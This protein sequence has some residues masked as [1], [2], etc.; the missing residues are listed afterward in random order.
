M[1]EPLKNRYN[2]AF[3]GRLVGELSAH[4]APFDGDAFARQLFDSSWPE[5]ELKQRMRHITGTLH[6]YLPA[7]YRQTLEILKPVSR[8]FSGFEPMFFPDYVECYG[9]DDYQAS[10]PALAHFTQYS[11]SEFAVR[12]FIERYGDEMMLQMQRW[13]ESDNHH[14]RR[15]ASEGCRPRL[16]WAMAL[17]A[18]KKNPEAV[19]EVISKMRCDESE[20]VR[21]SVANNLND[22]SKDHPERLLQLAQAWL[23]EDEK[24]DWIVKHACRSE[25]K[26]GV[27]EVLK[28]FG[29]DDPKHIEISAF[30]LQPEVKMGDGVGF[31]FQLTT[32]KKSLGRLRIEYA[33]DFMKA[34]GKQR[35]KVFKISESDVV[36]V[37]KSVIKQHSFRV[38]ST[39][40]YYPGAHVLAVIVNGR[41]LSKLSFTLAE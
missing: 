32:A 1:A 34:N 36:E 25:L 3:I 20:Y 22:I 9:L 24:T 33:I 13:A 17:P 10:I 41:V 28:L 14:I 40:K 11:S 35:R 6:A 23:G 4:H 30:T 21:R 37:Q 12:P 31:S 8:H 19:I 39:R 5:R 26:R 16:P 7:D 27:P 38:I 29:F 2:E 18:F 15:L